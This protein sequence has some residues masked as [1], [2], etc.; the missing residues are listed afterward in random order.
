MLRSLGTEI[1]SFTSQWFLKYL[2][3]FRH[4]GFSK[5][6]QLIEGFIAIVHGVISSVVSDTKTERSTPMTQVTILQGRVSD[7]RR[8]N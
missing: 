7:N 3:Q 8:R 4:S 1:R 2:K 5:L 6:L